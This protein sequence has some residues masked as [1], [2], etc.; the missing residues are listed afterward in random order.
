[1][2]DLMPNTGAV[3]FIFHILGIA[4]ITYVTN[5][6][7]TGFADWHRLYHDGGIAKYQLEAHSTNAARGGLP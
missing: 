2:D 6:N 3:N 5:F 7:F 4:V 1:M